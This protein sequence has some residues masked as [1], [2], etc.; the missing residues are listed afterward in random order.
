MRVIKRNG[1]E[2]EF[3]KQ[4]IIDA[5]TNAFMET[6]EGIDEDLIQD[7]AD[8]IEEEIGELVYYP[9]VESIQDMVEEA[10]MSSDRKD[11][12]KR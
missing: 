7:I 10:L 12:A 11:V 6:E 4:K 5:M 3:D 2:V 1:Q 9:T 8:E